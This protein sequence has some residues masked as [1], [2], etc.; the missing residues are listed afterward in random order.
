MSFAVSL[1]R[2][3]PTM[4]TSNGDEFCTAVRLCA[5]LSLGNVDRYSRSDSVSLIIVNYNARECIVACVL[6]VFNQ[7][8]E[9]IVVDNASNDDS[10]A[11]LRPP[12]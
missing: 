4:G 8:D 3:L 11:N 10:L 5:S 2:K 6:S 1:Y 9:V 12:F 7:V